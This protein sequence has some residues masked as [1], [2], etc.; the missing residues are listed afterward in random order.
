MCPLLVE[1]PPTSSDCTVWTS[2]NWPSQIRVDSWVARLATVSSGC[3]H[4]LGTPLLLGLHLGFKSTDTENF[5]SCPMTRH[6]SSYNQLC[7]HPQYPK[8]FAFQLYVVLHMPRI[9]F[10]FH[11]WSSV[12]FVSMNFSLNSQ[13]VLVSCGM[14]ST[15]AVQRKLR[16]S[17][18]EHFPLCFLKVVSFHSSTLTH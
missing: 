18:Q 16:A 6:Q 1:K 3:I 2:S 13:C 17:R 9:D 8:E 15:A 11:L 4:I 5:G 12:I 14:V 10:F 7:P